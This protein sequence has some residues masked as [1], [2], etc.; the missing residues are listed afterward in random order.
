MFLLIFALLFI[1]LFF[2]IFQ[3]KFIF[4][5]L[6]VVFYICTLILSNLNYRYFNNKF[7]LISGGVYVQKVKV[8]RLKR[9]KNKFSH[10]AIN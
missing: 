9:K 5:I 6:F 8:K 3:V 2:F 1:H 10:E 4:V 7:D